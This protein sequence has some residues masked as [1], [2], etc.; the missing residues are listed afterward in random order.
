[1]TDFDERLERNAENSI[2]WSNA[3]GNGLAMGTA[4]MDFKSPQCVTDALIE[5]AQQGIFAYEAKPESYYQAILGWY[6]RRFEW[7]IEKDWL[8]NGPGVWAC[9]RMC[10]DTFTKPGDGILVSTPHFHPI[11]DIVKNSG[12]KMVLSELKL[13]NGRYEYDMEDFEKK[14][15]QVSMYILINPQ[16]PTGRVFSK[17]E[18]KAV[19]DACIRHGV[20]I[21]SDE[22]HGNIAFTGHKHTPI[23][24]VSEEIGQN[25]IVLAAPS[26]AFNLQGLT[27]GYGIIPNNGLRARFWETMTGYDFDFAT[28]LFSMTAL[29]AA[30]SKGEEWLEELTKYLEGNLNY[31]CDYIAAEIPQIEVI[32]PEGAYMA[33]LD[34]RRLGMTPGQLQDLFEEKAG[35]FFTRGE[36]F[37][38][39]G[40]GFERINFACPRSVLEEAMRRM[41]KAIEEI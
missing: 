4:D 14:L 33:W 26:K 2:K 18:L 25:S 3:R 32:R 7:K 34:C 39:A 11:N 13:I 12:R 9:M 1:M 30:Y 41:K 8:V 10:V 19:G 36:T 38:E 20:L 29:T 22:V 27:Y 5:K 24:A 40:N 31:L 37:G 17:E 28:N 21:V 6:E 23:G 15:E 16:N 35:I